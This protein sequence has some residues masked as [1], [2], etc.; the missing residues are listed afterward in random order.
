MEIL[1]IIA[2][3]KFQLTWSWQTLQTR[4]MLIK[5]LQLTFKQVKKL[6]KPDPETQDTLMDYQF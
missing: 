6:L 3:A 2:S 5:S 4:K 1:S